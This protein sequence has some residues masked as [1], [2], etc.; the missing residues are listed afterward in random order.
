MDH[1]IRIIAQFVDKATTPIKNLTKTT[2]ELTTQQK[3]LN[4]WSSKYGVTSKAL[5]RG[6]RENNFIMLRSGAIYDKVRGKIVKT[7]YA[8]TKAASSTKRF[9]FEW[10][11]VMFAGMALDRVFG[12]LIRK[13]LDLFGVSKML[14]AAW[15]VVLLPVMTSIVLPVLL[16]LI[17]AFIN[18]PEKVKLSIGILVPVSYTH[19]TLPTN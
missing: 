3:I 13:Q 9:K 10:L 2:N 12:G 15:T 6:L 14:E 16:R 11:S 7:N 8:M 18:L 4:K 1:L 17:D 19:L 5:R